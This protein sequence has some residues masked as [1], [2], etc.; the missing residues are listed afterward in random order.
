M[1]YC[2]IF[3]MDGV[4]V[5]SYEAHYKSW[6]DVA[7]EEGIAITEADFARSF[8]R[9]SREI[10][11]STWPVANLDDSRIQSIDTRK[12]EAFRRIINHQF[13]VMDGAPELLDAL[14]AAGFRLA[15][16]SSAPPENVALALDR[17]GGAERFNGIVHGMDVQR[18]KPDPQ[19]FLMAAKRA[20]VEAG[21]CVVIED[22]RPGVEAAH[23]AGMAAVAFL[24]TGRSAH[25]FDGIHP[26]LMAQS[27]RELT[28]E[29]LAALVEKPRGKRR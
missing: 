29:R 27:L 2:V 11:R 14:R 24:S 26:D 10:I 21:R 18:G 19:V 1:T 5:D 8:G 20:G 22:A 12:E 13:P 17:L 16:G 15:V 4:L 25:D 9:T 28:P 23:R 7:A 6:R 3:D